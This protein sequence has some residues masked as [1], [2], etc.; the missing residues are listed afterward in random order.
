[1]VFLRTITPTRLQKRGNTQN[2]AFGHE[3]VAFGH[4]IL[5]VV[6]SDIWLTSTI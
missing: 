4:E 2:V 6:A 5:I 3:I 1:M